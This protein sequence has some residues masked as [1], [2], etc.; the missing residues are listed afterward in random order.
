LK[1]EDGEDADLV[2]F[3]IT[4]VACNQPVGGACT[5]EAGNSPD[6]VQRRLEVEI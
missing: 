3:R 2:R 1:N 5:G 6:F 4:A